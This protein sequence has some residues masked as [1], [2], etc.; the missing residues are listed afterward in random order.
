MFYVILN[1]RKS[2][3]VMRVNFITR[4]FHA[5]ALTRNNVLHFLDSVSELPWPGSGHSRG[6]KRTWLLELYTRF[7]K[8]GVS[9]ALN[10]WACRR[11]LYNNARVRGEAR[12]SIEEGDRRSV[13]ELTA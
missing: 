6:H 2:N 13:S 7:S 10:V 11:A 1:T 3:F 5:A 4:T 9:R 8:V 12:H